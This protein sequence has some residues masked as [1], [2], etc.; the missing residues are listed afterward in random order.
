MSIYIYIYIDLL[1]YSRL[2][3]TYSIAKSNRPDL[4]TI[5]LYSSALA[6]RPAL[7]RPS[8]PPGLPAW[9]ISV[10]LAR[11]RES[12]MRHPKLRIFPLTLEH[13]KSP[14]SA[15]FVSMLISPC[16]RLVID[17]F[18]SGFYLPQKLQRWWPYFLLLHFPVHKKKLFWQVMPL[19]LWTLFYNTRG[20]YCK[21]ASL[22]SSIRLLSI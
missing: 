22:D 12:I 13:P 11:L 10:I 19:F 4:R 21:F 7:P 9:L 5:R 6:E 18:G 17:F 2:Q 20:L 8:V 14:V 16:F 15:S 1:P 3:N